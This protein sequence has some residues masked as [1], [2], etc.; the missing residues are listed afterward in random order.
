MLNF[1]R[2]KILSIIGVCLFGI[3]MALPNLFTK[4]QL[5]EMPE[6]MPKGQINLGLDL[7]GGVHL[8]LEVGIHEVT[9]Q[10]LDQLRAGISETLQ[11][12]GVRRHSRPVVDGDA[13]KVTITNDRDVD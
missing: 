6:W 9:A 3:W 8:L 12:N 7:Q 10:Q 4:E 11:D 5:A 2:W 13:V 1:S